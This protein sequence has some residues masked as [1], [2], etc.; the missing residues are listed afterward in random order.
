VVVQQIFRYAEVLYYFKLKMYGQECT[1]CMVRMYS[2]C[3]PEL[4]ASSSGTVY[5]CTLELTAIQV[6]DVHSIHS[7][8]AVIPFP[9]HFPHEYHNRF[10]VVERPGLDASQL[11]GLLEEADEDA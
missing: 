8:V 2:Q 7:V 10:F 11:G 9:T 5:S 3:I 4:Y 6:F 1:L